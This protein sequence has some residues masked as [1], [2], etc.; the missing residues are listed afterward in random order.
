MGSTVYWYWY[1]A[2]LFKYAVFEGRSHRGEY[3]RFVLCDLVIILVLIVLS[4]V[5]AP[6]RVIFVL[7]R[8]AVAVPSIAVTIR[9]LHD[10]GRSGWWWLICL[11]PV[12][13]WIVILIYLVQDSQPGSNRYGPNP[14]EVT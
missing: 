12:V 3:W 5:V 9:R 6:F 14:G 7:Y 13:G 10:T 2:V 4:V 1:L 8:L 11:V